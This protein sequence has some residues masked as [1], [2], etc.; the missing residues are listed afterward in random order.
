MPSSAEMAE[1]HALQACLREL[2]RRASESGAGAAGRLQTLTAE[3][4]QLKEHL[5][6]A[7]ADFL[8]Y[9]ERA[10]KDLA[11][12]EELALRNYVLDLLPILDH[13]DLAR[14][15]AKACG[16]LDA[17]APSA[18]EQDLSPA[19][20]VQKALALIAESLDQALRVRGLEPIRAQGRPYDPQ[21]HEAVVVRPADAAKGEEPNRVV[22]ELRPGYLWKGLLLRSA[23][24]VLTGEAEPS[25]KK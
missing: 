17:P 21:F 23:Q 8:N 24:V 14:A 20:R 6:R 16:I 2:V 9:Q 7:R 10:A 5:A 12:A 22:E 18:A 13:L 3:R 25:K 11:R 15:D 19:Q 1:L 4:D